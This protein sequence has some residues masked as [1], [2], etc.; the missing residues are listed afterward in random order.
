[1]AE[2]HREEIAKLEALYAAN[3]EGRVFVHLAEAL[4][5]AGERERARIILEEGLGRHPDSASGY[6]VYGRVLKDLGEAGDAGAAFRRV[7]D[8]DSGNLVA[9]RGLGDLALSE[10]R[11]ADAA[12]FYREVL[13]RNPTNE[14]VR[15]LVLGIEREAENLSVP[16]DAVAAPSAAP[17][18]T[19]AAT[20]AE[21]EYGI[22]EIDTAGASAAV[23]DM[24]NAVADT[25][26]GTGTVEP[27]ATLQE[28]T[29]DARAVEPDVAESGDIDEP[30][31]PAAGS[32]L[33]AAPDPA[34]E[35]DRGVG[36]ARSFDTTPD[37]LEPPIEIAGLTDDAV[38]SFGE[39]DVSGEGPDDA[40]EA[41]EWPDDGPELDIA[42]LL[43][44]AAGGPFDLGDD[45]AEDAADPLD[46]DLSVPPA[47]GYDAADSDVF[48]LQDL[49]LEA[50]GD[51]AA[52]LDEVRGLSAWEQAED[53][54]EEAAAWALDVDVDADM[55][56]WVEEAGDGAPEGTDVEEEVWTLD[57]GA[58]YGEF[59]ATDETAAAD[60]D[61]EGAEK[62]PTGVVPDS[63][64]AAPTDDVDTYTPPVARWPAP[65]APD[66]DVDPD[67]A[68]VDTADDAAEWREHDAP[69]DDDEPA[70]E[71]EVLGFEAAEP[72]DAEFETGHTGAMAA[73]PAEHAAEPDELEFEAVEPEDADLDAAESGP[74][75]FET[76]YAAG[77]EGAFDAGDS[78]VETEEVALLADESAPPRGDAGSDEAAEPAP[79]DVEPLPAA[80]ATPPSGRGLYEDGEYAFEPLD[81]GLET[82]TMADLYR[83]QGFTSRA[84]DVYRTLLRRR[85]DD[86]RLAT[87][88]AELEELGRRPLLERPPE[89]AS[90]PSPESAD[91][92]P[93]AE[94]R[95]EAARTA[96]GVTDDVSDEAWLRQAGS[97]WPAEETPAVTDAVP[98]AWAGE[99]AEG[100]PV[101]VSAAIGDY[102]QELVGWRRP[103]AL[104]T[105]PPPAPQPVTA[106]VGGAPAGEE[107]G[108]EDGEVPPE[109][110]VSV[111]GVQDQ[112]AGDDSASS[113]G[114]P[115]NAGA[116]QQ[117][118]ATAAAPWAAVEG[119]AL[120]PVQAA[121]EE[122]YGAAEPAEP[123]GGPDGVT[124]AAD[125]TAQDAAAQ[126]DEDLAMFRSWLQSLRK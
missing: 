27:P 105:E 64:E 116:A 47:A 44:A 111:T 18:E 11:P 32:D 62:A 108:E 37:T 7:L 88:L 2:S 103:A 14:E 67:A 99:P 91:D 51:Q 81:A 75:E 15:G 98:F 80:E 31:G 45:G 63:D 50:A 24:G 34:M 29:G 76:E 113:V 85:P 73:E 36:T 61:D 102:L 100:E 33:A 60:A 55:A 83:S 53:L 58:G 13:S 4:R 72:G 10:D 121:F 97:T 26:D 48:D 59:A 9:L 39:P 78:V 6:V 56:R 89:A 16:V 92:E 95:G 94:Q 21:P 19:G 70:F 87:K 25:A 41:A 77:F 69:A 52:G 109:E 30:V 124:P 49:A 12:A 28:R 86:E 35:P 17:G 115:W 125:D 40:L 84:A 90:A 96:G 38:E 104:V 126:D 74:S 68:D 93:A 22:V 118:D 117:T 57:T 106:G 43:A 1:M 79:L 120:D 20:D 71:L 107:D 54:D 101:D 82:E 119:G 5:K 23:A 46:T 8:L 66:I 42:A 112:P 123:A 3:P 110:P 122:W 114:E 65:A